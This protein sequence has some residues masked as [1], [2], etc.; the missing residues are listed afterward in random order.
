MVEYIR[1]GSP[2]GKWS[3]M[4]TQALARRVVEL[5]EEKQA[6][7]IMLLDL[8]SLRTFADFFV[9]CSGGSERQLKSLLDVVDEGVAEE[10]GFETK[11]EG[12]TSAGWVLLDYGDV[13][14][15]IFSNEMRDFYRLERLWDAATPLVVVQ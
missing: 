5:L 9:I 6:S 2:R 11:T 3:G 8:R 1:G 10:F 4:D 14:V 13:V 7:D 12:M 15:H